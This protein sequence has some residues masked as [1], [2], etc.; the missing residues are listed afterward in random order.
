MYTGKLLQKCLGSIAT[1][2]IAEFI[3][4]KCE[5]RPDEHDCVMSREA[6]FSMIYLDDWVRHM[7]QAV[8]YPKAKREW[9]LGKTFQGHSVWENHVV[10]AV[11][12]VDVNRDV[13][14]W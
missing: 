4:G 2:D 6:R 11:D 12:F 3:Y 5:H 14:Q 13:S 10:Y 1:P 9:L 7:C 8:V